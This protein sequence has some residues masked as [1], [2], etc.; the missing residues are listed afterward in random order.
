MKRKRFDEES[1]VTL[2]LFILQTEEAKPKAAEPA[3]AEPETKKEEEPAPAEPEKKKEEEAEP[4]KKEEEEAQEKP[5]DAK[6]KFTK[7]IKSQNLMEG[8]P[9][10]L[11]CVI[12]GN[13]FYLFYNNSFRLLSRCQ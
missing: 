8:D 4:K 10:T 5:A 11:D 9:L 13:Y 12:E 3:P 6:P 2:N 7:H 1:I